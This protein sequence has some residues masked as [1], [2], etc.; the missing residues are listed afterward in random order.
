M[1]YGKPENAGKTHDC[2]F[3]KFHEGK[4]QSAKQIR[5][6]YS[7]HFFSG[8]SLMAAIRRVFAR[9]ILDSRGNPT[10]ECDVE[11]DD[12]SFGRAAV[13]SGA[14]TGSHEAVELRDGGKRFNGKGVRTAVK[15]VNSVI[16]PRIKGMPAAGQRDIDSFLIELDATPNKSK[17]GANA[18]LGVSLAVARA[19]SED[20]G[21]T[22]YEHL[23]ALFGS[24]ASYLPVPFAN[25]VNGNRHAGNELAFQEFMVAAVGAKSYSEAVQVTS[26]IYHELKAWLLEKHGKAA[27]NVGDEGGFAPPMRTSREALDAVFD[28]VEELGYQKKAK[29]AVDCAAS[30]FYRGGSYFVDGKKFSAG[31][32]MDYYSGLVST[33]PIVSVEDPFAED[34]FD[35]FAAFTRRVGSKV[36]V[37]GDDLLVTNVSR[38]KRAAKHKSCNAL[39]LKVNQIGTL[40]QSLDA[41]R[42]A[43]DNKWG[44]MVSHRSAETCDSFIS[45]LS[46]ALNSRQIKLGAPCRSERTEKYNRLLRI[47]EELGSR[48]KYRW[49]R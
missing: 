18:I 37:V 25:L 10:I 44:V 32:L 22:L 30:E 4:T 38:M 1:L 5:F 45:D 9:E 34:D 47:E 24:K 48:A 41:A 20:L 42:L 46:V 12:G 33:Y 8:E 36:Q 16:S 14:S 17:L 3:K 19:A 23:S 21:K 11:L 26:E 27:V 6:L 39:L 2:A 15:N 28:A 40:S 13:P 7:V 29:L 35:A 31:G 43:F 49:I